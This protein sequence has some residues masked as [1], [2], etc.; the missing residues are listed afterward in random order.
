VDVEPSARERVEIAA[1]RVKRKVPARLTPHRPRT[2]GSA[3]SGSRPVDATVSLP[4]S[5]SLTNRVLVLSPWPQGRRGCSDRCK[6]ET[7]RLWSTDCAPSARASRLARDR[8]GLVRG[9]WAGWD[10]RYHPG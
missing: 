3:P 4:G 5:K 1:R 6:L 10:G 9:R 8:R 7:P 2:G